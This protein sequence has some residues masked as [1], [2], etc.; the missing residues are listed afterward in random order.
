[1]RNGVINRR[2]TETLSLNGLTEHVIGACIEIHHALVTFN[3]PVLKAG[4]KRIVNGLQASA[5]LR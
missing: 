2:D 4:I 3:V 5:S 1:M